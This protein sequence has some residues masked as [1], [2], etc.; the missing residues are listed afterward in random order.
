MSKNNRKLIPCPECGREKSF[1]GLC[2]WCQARKKREA[3][4]ALT[5]Q[6]ISTMIGNIIAKM[7][8]DKYEDV[9]D[10]LFSLIAY[11]D[12]NTEK[13]ADTA[14]EK[15]LFY[16]AMLYKDASLALQEKLIALLLDPQCSKSQASDILCALA[17][18]RSDRAREVFYHLE[19]HPMPWRKDLYVNPSIYAQ[20]GGW[21]FDDQG[22]KIEL[23]YKDCYAIQKEKRADTAI[24]IG[25]KRADVCPVCGCQVVDILT[26]DGNDKRLHFLGIQGK[27]KIPICPNCA[28]MCEKTIVRY[29]LDGASSFEIVE[30]FGDENYMSESDFK[31]L[32]NNEL[33][34]SLAKKPL[35]YSMGSDELCTVGGS[36]QWIQD[37]QYEICPDCGKKMR[38]LAA[39]SLEE[40]FDGSEGTLYIEICTDCS[41]VTVVHQQT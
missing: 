39:L 33:V 22:N 11:H 5:S 12:I 21:T 29:T 41:I 14:F 7:K 38:L 19:K 16:P 40:I 28:S 27:V 2:W 23:I 9:Q 20:D 1:E 36:P 10:D 17:A 18:T 34:L 15:N 25:T 3:F 4:E 6:E 32:E 35:Y 8:E 26:I 13:I 37:P 30:P 31:A 24:H